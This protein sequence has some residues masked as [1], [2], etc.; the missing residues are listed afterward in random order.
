MKRTTTIIIGAGQAGLAMSHHLNALSIDHV[1]L[2]RG[3]I[4]H[5]WRAE[6][7]DSLRLLTPNWQSR[8]PGYSYRGPNPDGYRDMSQTVDFLASYAQSIA[9][10]VET[11]TV[12]YSVRQTETGYK[13]M[14]N[15]G[16]WACRTLVIASGACNIAN[17]PAI[18]QE[19]PSGIRSITP[20]DY[21]NPSQLD[22][23]GVLVVGA[24][25]SGVQLAKEI[26]ESGRQVTI[27]TGEHVR[28]PRVYRG[29]DIQ[30]WMDKS[31]VM[32][33]DLSEVDDIRRARNV[34]SLQLI[35]T[36]SHENID[37]NSLQD[38]GIQ[39]AGRMMDI[40]GDT[41]QFSGSLQHVCTL[42]DLKM[43]R[44]LTGIDDWISERGLSGEMISAHRPAPTTFPQEPLVKLDLRAANIKTVVWAT[45]Y[46]P[47]YSWLDVDVLDRKGAL[48]HQGGIVDA[49]GMYVLGLPFLRRRK[50]NLIDGVGDDAHDL[51]LYIQSLL[52][53]R[54][55]IAA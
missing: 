21:K 26:Q 33:M 48:R 8:L 31:G 27:S 2:E 41:V 37:L 35:G 11:N 45:G 24:S 49:P 13:V 34:P 30:Y 28:I 25:A 42:A 44:L 40:F 50:S 22:E 54:A 51:S 10:P 9:A 55:A 43:K 46:R 23:G 4:A 15:R 5:S 17:M 6:R 39:V 18:A 14:T 38:L 20:M 3:E 16:E 53:G 1:I 32:N 36:P 19:L 7:W 12:V 29:K 47:D 52:S